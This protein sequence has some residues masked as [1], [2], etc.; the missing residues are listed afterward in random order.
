MFHYYPYTSLL[1]LPCPGYR[2]EEGT[3]G[4]VCEEEVHVRSGFARGI[5]RHLQSNKSTSCSDDAELERNTYPRLPGASSTSLEG[6]VSPSTG[7]AVTT[8]D[9]EA[10]YRILGI[11][12]QHADIL[13]HSASRGV[14]R[15]YRHLIALRIRAPERAIRAV[16]SNRAQCHHIR[17]RPRAQ[18]HTPPSRA[19]P[20]AILQVTQ[21]C[22]PRYRIRMAA[23]AL[24]RAATPAFPPKS[25]F[26]T[27]ADSRHAATWRRLTT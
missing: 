7:A 26:V 24:H 25:L 16:P 9:C 13:R 10:A 6:L 23:G 8:G 14:G 22:R 27:C 1:L 20:A 4:D 15:V 18:A 5:C 11:R 3:A 12:Y 17:A 21:A 2:L 19:C